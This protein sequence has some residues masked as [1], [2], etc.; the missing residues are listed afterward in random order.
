[1]HEEFDSK[2]SQRNQP[3]KTG[4]QLLG[5]QTDGTAR[6]LIN[7]PVLTNRPVN[8]YIER[9]VDHQTG[10]QGLWLWHTTE[11]SEMIGKVKLVEINHQTLQ[12][13]YQG[14]EWSIEYTKKNAENL[15]ALSFG[16]TCFMYK[17]GNTKN[18]ISREQFLD[19]LHPKV[20]TILLFSFF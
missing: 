18:I 4:S 19:Y 8:A 7:Q 9:V 5:K 3:L 1:M 10:E 17:D 13:I 2:K 14:E 11:Q 20:Q 16:K 6:T 12:E 15:A